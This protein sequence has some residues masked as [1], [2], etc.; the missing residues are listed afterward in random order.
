MVGVCS[1]RGWHLKDEEK[2]LG[3]EGRAGSRARKK[4][5]RDKEGEAPR[6]ERGEG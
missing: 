4:T 2:A 3:V 1:E 5:L 6:E